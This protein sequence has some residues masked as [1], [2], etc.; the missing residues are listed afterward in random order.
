VATKTFYQEQT[1]NHIFHREESNNAD[2]NDKCNFYQARWNGTPIETKRQMNLPKK[3]L[4]LPAG[5]STF[6]GGLPK[7]C[8]I[9]EKT[10]IKL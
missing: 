4:F 7:I 1:L 3:S 9:K 5:S 2:F 6:E 10:K 8:L